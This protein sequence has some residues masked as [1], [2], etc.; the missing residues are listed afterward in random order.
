VWIYICK[1]PHPLRG[2]RLPSLCRFPCRAHTA[3]RLPQ[4]RSEGAEDAE[5]ACGEG[6]PP[7]AT[8]DAEAACGEGTRRADRGAEGG[9]TEKPR[10]EAPADAVA[11]LN[12]RDIAGYAAK[13]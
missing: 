13:G 11:G 10:S 1:I 4:G 3:R 2:W 7:T 6:L 12:A 8:A 9:G 5:A